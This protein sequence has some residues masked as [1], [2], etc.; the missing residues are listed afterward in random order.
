M[1]EKSLIKQIE[2]NI[3]EKAARGIPLTDEEYFFYEIALFLK[4]EGLR[5]IIFIG[6]EEHYCEAVKN[7]IYDWSNKLGILDKVKTIQNIK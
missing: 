6:M 2:T 5:H 3:Y 7:N 1:I 4:P